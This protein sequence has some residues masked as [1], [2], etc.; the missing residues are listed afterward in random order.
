MK[1]NPPQKR[2]LI[3]ILCNPFNRRTRRF[4]KNA[5]VICSLLFIFHCGG[6]TQIRDSLIFTPSRDASYPY[7]NITFRQPFP[8][9]GDR[10]LE[11]IAGGDVMIGH[12]TA[13]YLNKLGSVYPLRKIRPSLAGYDII[14][15]NLEAPLEDSGDVVEGKKFTI[16]VP[17]NHA[18]GL[19]P[20][21]FNIVTVAPNHILDLG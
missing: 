10:V 11:I 7:K 2:N 14:F 16:K 3:Q 12:W 20:A 8:Q 18:T 9:P 1:A 19:L 15:A 6:G 5:A 21:G 17:T 4:A 13:A